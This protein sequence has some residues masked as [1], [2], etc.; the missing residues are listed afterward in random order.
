MSTDTVFDPHP[1]PSQTEVGE[2]RAREIKLRREA[3]GRQV[4]KVE[5]VEPDRQ[6]I[7]DDLLARIEPEGR[8]LYSINQDLEKALLLSIAISLCS[9]AAAPARIESGAGGATPKGVEPRAKRAKHPT[10]KAKHVRRKVG[11][12]PVRKGSEGR[13]DKDDK[14]D[15]RILTEFGVSSG[16]PKRRKGDIKAKSKRYL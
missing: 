5:P 16:A 6:S 8:Q 15:F 10:H 1:E 11:R 12:L 9:S 4:G 13:S 7:S 3:V 2:Q 14:R